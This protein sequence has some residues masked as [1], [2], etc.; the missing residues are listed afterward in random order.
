M[1]TCCIIIDQFYQYYWQNKEFWDIETRLLEQEP[2]NIKI[3]LIYRI[4]LCSSFVLKSLFYSNK[5]HFLKDECKQALNQSLPFLK[6]FH[7][8]IPENLDSIFY[9]LKQNEL[10]IRQLLTT[11]FTKN[12]TTKWIQEIKKDLFPKLK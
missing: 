9:E 12:L 3:H 2:E 8:L 5:L 1:N 11:K 6:T 7:I 10:H 4:C